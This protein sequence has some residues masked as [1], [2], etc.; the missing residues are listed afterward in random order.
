MH[1]LVSSYRRCLLIFPEQ[2]VIV[3]VESVEVAATQCS[4][5]SQ[6]LPSGVSRVSC[7]LVESVEVAATQCSQWRWSQWRWS[8]WRWS[9]W[10]WVLPEGSR[11]PSP[12][13]SGGT[14]PW[15]GCTPDWG[16]PLHPAGKQTTQLSDVR[17]HTFLLRRVHELRTHTHAGASVKRNCTLIVNWRVAL[18]TCL[19]LIFYYYGKVR[20]WVQWGT[21]ITFQPFNKSPLTKLMVLYS[22]YRLLARL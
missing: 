13:P 5:W 7:Y 17:H 21:L 4:Q 1:L 16:A 11:P 6:L 20:T 2:L 19:F 10:R 3:V 15:P 14:G 22:Q 12:A 18:M 8:Q 9:Q